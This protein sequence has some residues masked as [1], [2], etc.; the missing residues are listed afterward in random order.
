M[1]KGA[2]TRPPTPGAR[3]GYDK[4]TLFFNKCSFSLSLSS[5]HMVSFFLIFTQM[6][7]CC[8]YIVFLADNLK[9]VESFREGGRIKD[10][11]K[12]DPLL[13]VQQMAASFGGPS[14][15]INIK[16]KLK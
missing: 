3:N 11:E 10:L 7:F 14:V 6:G 2:G 13:V 16:S 8:V 5:R 1:T 12:E 15:L 9:Q 4:P